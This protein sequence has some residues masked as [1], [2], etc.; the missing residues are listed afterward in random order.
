MKKLFILFCLLTFF[1][2]VNYW[3]SRPEKNPINK[4][5]V[6]MEFRN[7]PTYNVFF[8]KISYPTRGSFNTK[9]LCAI[10]SAAFN[11]PNAIVYVYTI[12]SQVPYTYRKM[13]N[14]YVNLRFV[15]LKP[16][17]V[18]ANTGFY[19]WW[20]QNGTLLL[21]SRFRAVHLSDLARVALLYKFGGV[22]SDLDTMNIKSFESLIE[23]SGLTGGDGRSVNNAVV[24]FSRDHPILEKVID[25]VTSNY[26]PEEWSSNGPGAIELVLKRNC[27]STDIYE[28]KK[29]HD[30]CGVTI[31]PPTFFYPYGFPT[32]MYPFEK[33]SKRNMKILTQTYSIH[34][35]NIVNKYKVYYGDNSIYEFLAAKNCPLIY[36]KLKSNQIAYL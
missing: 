20:V 16:K 34:F 32:Y 6:Y 26:S 28:D 5:A 3:A 7:A 14:E 9:E 19:S 15:E 33:N 18:F 17:E 21:N 10:E 27:N 8:I 36:E 29:L 22:Y 11:N 30:K 31:Y 13:L 2:I 23:T 25:Q 1:S 4:V 24:V 35:Y 12:D